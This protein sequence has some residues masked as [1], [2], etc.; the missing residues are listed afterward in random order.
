MFYDRHDYIAALKA[1]IIGN[2]A[3]VEPLCALACRV[4][5]ICEE[6]GI[7]ELPMQARALEGA[8]RRRGL[9]PLTEDQL[10]RLI[11]AYTRNCITYVDRHADLHTRDDGSFQCSREKMRLEA[12]YPAEDLVRE[13]RALLG[14]RGST[15][16]HG[17][18]LDAIQV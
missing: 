8:W 15:H 17:G 2:V 5:T 13:W 4:L 14:T 16:L 9:R 11:R 10:T 3:Q 18:D 1:E 6:Q 12:K 7:N